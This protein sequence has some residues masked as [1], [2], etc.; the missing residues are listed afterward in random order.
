MSCRHTNGLNLQLYPMAQ[1]SSRPG[2]IWA[3]IKF[4]FVAASMLV[5]SGIAIFA[6]HPGDPLDSL[7]IRKKRRKSG[8]GNAS[9]HAGSFGL[10]DIPLWLWILIIAALILLTVAIGFIAAGMDK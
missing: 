10:N 5:V 9:S 3:G 4:F 1:S 2:S 7:D 6:G 8:S